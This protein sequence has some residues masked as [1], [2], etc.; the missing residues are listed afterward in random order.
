MSDSNL[1]NRLKEIVAEAEDIIAKIDGGVLFEVNEPIDRDYPEKYH[2]LID[3]LNKEG[4]WK[5]EYK[6]IEFSWGDEEE[7]VLTDGFMN[8][9]RLLTDGDM[10]FS[11]PCDDECE[12]TFFDRNE[13]RIIMQLHQIICKN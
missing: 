4:V 13:M 5:V 1:I 11:R 3:E 10:Y 6:V 7:L 12:E 8:S 9:V 2:A